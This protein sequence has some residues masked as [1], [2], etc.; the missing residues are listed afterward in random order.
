MVRVYSTIATPEVVASRLA[1]EG[2]EVC[3]YENQSAIDIE[4]A[5]KVLGWAPTPFADVIQATTGWHTP[6]LT[7]DSQK[8]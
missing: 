1:Q 6:H 3:N 7:K 4:K 5:K 2:P 8:L